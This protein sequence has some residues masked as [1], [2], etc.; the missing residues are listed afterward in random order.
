MTELDWD[1]ILFA[2]WWCDPF[3]ESW[4]L[5]KQ[6]E[7]FVKLNAHK[8]LRFYYT[9]AGLK[10]KI[11]VRVRKMLFKNTQERNGGVGGQGPVAHPFFFF[12]TGGQTFP[13]PHPI[14]A[15]L[16]MILH[17]NTTTALYVWFFFCDFFFV[18]CGAVILFFPSPLPYELPTHFQNHYNPLIK[19][20]TKHAQ[21]F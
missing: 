21:S 20:K 4:F 15:G 11:W 12:F 1:D 7:R 14:L 18:L 5:Q 8:S 9:F 10:M 3:N 16:N 17:C 2:G 6:R 13:H 19:G